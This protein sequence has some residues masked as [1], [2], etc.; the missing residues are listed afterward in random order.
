MVFTK[1][2]KTKNYNDPKIKLFKE[3]QMIT[4]DNKIRWKFILF[5]GE[6]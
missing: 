6:H 2:F 3:E 1:D 5:E 4:E